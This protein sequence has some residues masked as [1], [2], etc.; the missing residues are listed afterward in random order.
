M[1]LIYLAAFGK[2]GFLA[3]P[4]VKDDLLAVGRF[5]FLEDADDFL[6][7][8][9]LVLTMV[10]SDWCSES[11]INYCHKILLILSSVLLLL[12]RRPSYQNLFILSSRLIKLRNQSF[13]IKLLKH[14]TRKSK[15]NNSFCLFQ[16]HKRKM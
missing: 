7:G 13:R 10:P 9:V 16:I 3:C 14:F 11:T 2:E 15:S 4:S 1:F 8:A 5:P 6:A 12:S